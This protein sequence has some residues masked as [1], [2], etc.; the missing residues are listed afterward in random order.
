MMMMIRMMLCHRTDDAVNDSVC[1]SYDT[2][3]KTYTYVQTN[4]ETLNSV[5]FWF[6]DCKLSFNLDYAVCGSCGF[7]SSFF[8]FF[9]VSLSFL[10]SA[11]LKV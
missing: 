4:W 6:S 2:Y 11:Y 9:S 5:S 3:I 8:L 1:S 7:F 10:F